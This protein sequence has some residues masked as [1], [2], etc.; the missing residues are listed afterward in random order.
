MILLKSYGDRLVSGKYEL[1]SRSKHAANFI[2]QNALACCV[3]ESVG[4]GPFSIVVSGIP[5]DSIKTL[6]IENKRFILNG[7]TLNF[8]RG[9]R[10]CSQIESLPKISR[11]KLRENLKYFGDHLKQ[12]SCP[13]SLLF[14]INP[15]KENEFK[16]DFENEYVRR[17][18]NG[19][20]LFF[21]SDCLQGVRRLRGLGF[22]LTP[23]GDDFLA[24]AM[25]AIH[26]SQSIF[27]ENYQERLLEISQ[28]ARGDNPIVNA[29]LE[30]A[31]DGAFVKRF[32]DVIIAIFRGNLLKIKQNTTQLLG[33]GKTSGVD[34]AVGYYLTLMAEL[35]RAKD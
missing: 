35:N 7:E 3:D 31:R 26:I 20:E 33:A 10:Y 21:D 29:Y 24:G 9:G 23:S 27:N 15:A 34:W 19:I 1:Y 4:P 16:T 12:L 5:I 22:G 11:E 17:F 25:A 30:S 2:C 28:A 6:Q 18:K 32:R 14:L 8:T 13:L